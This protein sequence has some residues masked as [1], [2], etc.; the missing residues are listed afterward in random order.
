[1]SKVIGYKAQSYLVD[2]S[3]DISNGDWADALHALSEAY[4]FI[5][6]L[7]FTKDSTGNPYMT[8]QEVNA[9]L[10]RLT[11]GSGGFWERTPE[12]LTAMAN[13][14]ALATGLTLP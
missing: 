11:D 6:G 4:G 7:Q 10:E 3:E 2:G 14:V 12:E 8:N 13:E 5:L 9:L 1:M